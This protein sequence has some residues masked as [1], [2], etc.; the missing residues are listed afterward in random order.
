MRRTRRPKPRMLGLPLRRQARRQRLERRPRAVPAT[1]DDAHRSD[2]GSGRKPQRVRPTRQ[3]LGRVLGPA[4][5]RVARRRRWRSWLLRCPDPDPGDYRRSAGQRRGMAR[6][7]AAGR[8]TDQVLGP[9][10]RWPPRRRTDRGFDQHS[11]G[12]GGCRRR[13]AHQHGI[14]A[15]LRRAQLGRRAML[16]TARRP[17]T[18]RRRRQRRLDGDRR[19][20]DGAL[21]RDTGRGRVSPHLRP[22]SERQRRVLG[23]PR[24]GASSPGFCAA[25]WWRRR[26]SDAPA[27]PPASSGAR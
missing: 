11:R 22:T 14:C 17:P 23:L 2:A 24:R 9:A 27:V 26:T 3:R 15:H 5:T 7:R 10:R 18:R 13:S 25:P 12:R 8:R 16:G 4:P 6:L 21:G 19:E 20:R 1:G